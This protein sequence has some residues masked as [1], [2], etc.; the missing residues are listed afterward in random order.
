MYNSTEGEAIFEGEDILNDINMDN[1]RNRLGICPQHDILFEDLTM[2]EH[3][4]I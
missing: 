3:L 1:F 4:E 2:K